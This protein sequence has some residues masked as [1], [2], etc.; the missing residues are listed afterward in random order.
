MGA[1][2]F[3]PQ[4]IRAQMVTATPTQVPTCRVKSGSC[5]YNEFDCKTRTGEWC[6]LNG[7][8][9]TAQNGLDC[10]NFPSGIKAT[11]AAIYWL[12]YF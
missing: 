7:P 12:E 9:V 2:L 1:A 11:A 10:K 5:A 6:C 3:S 8:A 4:T